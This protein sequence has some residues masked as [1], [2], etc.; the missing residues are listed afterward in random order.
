MKI[1][2]RRT[3]ALQDYWNW[4]WDELVSHDLPSFIDLVFKQTGQKV[5]YVGHS[6]VITNLYVVYLN[7]FN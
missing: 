7:L 3:R 1:K 2:M 4:T 5:H 6:M